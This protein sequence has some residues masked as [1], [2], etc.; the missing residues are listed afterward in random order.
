MMININH[1]HELG[2]KTFFLNCTAGLKAGGL[3]NFLIERDLVVDITN[4]IEWLED[5]KPYIIDNNSKVS[6][7]HNKRTPS[8]IVKYHQFSGY[9][10]IIPFVMQVVFNLALI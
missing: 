1:V 8:R 10:L 4:F 9:V 3:K 7:G 5:I 2:C 6:D